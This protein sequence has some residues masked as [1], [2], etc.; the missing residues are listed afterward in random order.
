[1]FLTTLHITFPQ[2]EAYTH[3]L[4]IHNYKSQNIKRPMES[5]VNHFKPSEANPS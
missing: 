4:Y 1:M 3:R 5:L 2:K